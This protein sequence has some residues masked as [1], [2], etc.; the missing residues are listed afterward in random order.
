ME[1]QR[2]INSSQLK[3]IAAGTMLLDHIGNFYW[4]DIYATLSTTSG[5]PRQWLYCVYGIIFFFGRIAFPLFAFQA[6][7][8]IRH[9][10]SPGHYLGR[11]LLFGLLSEIPFRRLI[12][13]VSTYRSPWPCT[14]VMFTL[15][16]AVLACICYR[17]LLSEGRPRMICLLP[18]LVLALLA[19][20]LDMDYGALGVLLVVLL[21]LSTDIKQKQVVLIIWCG[22]CYGMPLIDPVK[23]QNF[24]WAWFAANV[25]RMLY[26]MLSV[27]IIR[28]Y[29]G[30]KGRGSKYFFYLFYPLHLW[31]LAII[32]YI[33]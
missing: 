28:N 10:R 16:M 14:N 12:W 22:L 15:L 33:S 1:R 5:I 17:R 26:A 24:S 4:Y 32:N 18:G 20:Q 23:Y 27:L 6:A 3:W 7:A 11:L 9:T 31:I 29:N 21:Y 19:E 8:G 2:G 13:A 25:M 30:Q